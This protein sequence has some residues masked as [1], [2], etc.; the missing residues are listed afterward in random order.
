MTEV[1]KEV[2]LEFKEDEEAAMDDPW[3][4]RLLI[5]KVG[6][7]KIKQFTI[8]DEWTPPVKPGQPNFTELDNP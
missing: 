5:E 8:P 2:Q 1:S 7:T 6:D 3:V 4:N